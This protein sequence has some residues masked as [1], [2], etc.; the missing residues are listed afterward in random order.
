MTAGQGRIA[1]PIN[2]GLY[3]TVFCD[4]SFCPMTHAAGYGGWVK[5]GAEG[6]TLRVSGPVQGVTKSSDAESE[7][8]MATLLRAKHE[9]VE[10]HGKRVI[11]QTDCTS[12]IRAL[13]NSE[14]LRWLYVLAV[15]VRFK[16]VKGHQGY[17]CKRSSVNTWCDHAARRHMLEERAKAGNVVAQLNNQNLN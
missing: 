8:I 3:V 16:H 5:H 10:F 6:A 17:K 15:D 12:A 11:I 9:G 7:A 2:S 4:A 1:P 13:E 14:E